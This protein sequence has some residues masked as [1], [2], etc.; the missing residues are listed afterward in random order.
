MSA[1]ASS[2]AAERA[3]TSRSLRLRAGS[4]RG[5]LALAGMPFARPGGEQ[6]D[7]QR[8]AR[9]ADLV[10][11]LGV[12][13]GDEAA[14]AGDR[15]PVLLELHR[16]ARDHHPGPLVDLVL[17]KAFAGRQVDRDHARLWV[18]PQHLGLVWLNVQR[19]NVPGLH[20]REIYFSAGRYRRSG[21]GPGHPP[22]RRGRP[23]PSARAAA[24]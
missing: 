14:A 1:V 24:P 19:S 7:E 10:R 12:E 9:R 17:L 5:M 15:S 8:I 2:R 13:V 11:L 23:S 4:T 16:A 18:A 22:E 21:G 20:A 3:T 6:E